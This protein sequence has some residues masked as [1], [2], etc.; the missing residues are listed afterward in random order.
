[1]AQFA[2]IWWILRASYKAGDITYFYLL[3]RNNLLLKIMISNIW[4]F[5]HLEELTHKINTGGV[6]GHTRIPQKYLRFCKINFGHLCKQ[7][8]PKHFRTFFCPHINVVV[9]RGRCHIRCIEVL[10]NSSKF[11]SSLYEQN[12]HTENSK[13]C[14]FEDFKVIFK[15]QA[16]P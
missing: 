6:Y 13:R 14:H 9:L 16:A 11:Q 12:K 1:M 4:L 2:Q 10:T 3:V 5:L 7:T 8:A 15:K